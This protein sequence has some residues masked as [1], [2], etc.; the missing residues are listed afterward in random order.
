MFDQIWLFGGIFNVFLNSGGP[1]LPRMMVEIDHRPIF[2]QKSEFFGPL[3]GL[4]QKCLGTVGERPR[5]I[6]GSLQDTFRNV[7][8]TC[9][10]SVPGPPSSIFHGFPVI[11]ED[12]FCPGGQGEGAPMPLSLLSSSAGLICSFLK[13]FGAEFYA[14]NKG[15]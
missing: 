9:S 14:N 10:G 5:T 4:S 13:E 3:P 2:K 11:F 8:R 12:F 6:L 7:F 1:G 15:S